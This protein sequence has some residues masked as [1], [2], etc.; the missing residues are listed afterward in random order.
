[1]KAIVVFQEESGHPF[2]RVLK[3]NFKHCFVCLS[4]GPHWIEINMAL[5]VVD[6]KVMT[7]SDYD[8]EDFYR[9]QG[10]IV[11]LTSQRAMRP[12]K[13]NILYGT[14]MV[15]NCVGLVKSILGINTFSWTPY[16]LYKELT[17]DRNND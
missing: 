15:A 17:H 16:S 13:W 12:S 14:F 5:N 6:V 9:N 10:H 11:V 8:M 4:S 2:S 7:D 1:M 3:K